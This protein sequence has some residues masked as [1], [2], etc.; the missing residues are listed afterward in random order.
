M[1]SLAGDSVLVGSVLAGPRP[2]GPLDDGYAEQQ[3]A[4]KQEDTLQTEA[5]RYQGDNARV[6][7]PGQT[8]P[9]PR[10]VSPA[11]DGLWG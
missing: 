7:A 9:L 1:R 8:E 11:A 5:E 3:E 2:L 6:P 10:P 4:L